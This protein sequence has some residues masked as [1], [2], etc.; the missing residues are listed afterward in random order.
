MT[1]D[2]KDIIKY[3]THLQLELE[4]ENEARRKCDKIMIKGL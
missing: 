1:S 2:Q 4:E 3:L